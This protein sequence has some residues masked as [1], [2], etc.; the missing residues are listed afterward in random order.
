M[1]HGINTAFTDL[2]LVGLP[3]LLLALCVLF[4]LARWLNGRARC[5]TDY[6]C[7]GTR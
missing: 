5:L 2:A 4:A 1:V 3:P 7:R 6:L